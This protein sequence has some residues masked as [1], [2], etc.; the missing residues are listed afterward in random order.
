MER[1]FK[2][3]KGELFNLLLKK[4]TP[5]TSWKGVYIIS[6][7][8]RGKLKFVYL[9]DPKIKIIQ[10]RKTFQF[11][12]YTITY[13]SVNVKNIITKFNTGLNENLCKV[14]SKQRLL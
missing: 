13:F 5:V 8:F 12:E 11:K 10:L 9:D 4:I 7:E 3:K 6:K 14:S 1:L 2:K